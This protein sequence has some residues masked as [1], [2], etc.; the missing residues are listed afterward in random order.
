M[1]LTL[2]EAQTLRAAYLA[3][4]TA[5]ASGQSYTIGSRS[6]TRANLAEVKK[7]FAEYDA[8]VDDLTN[9]TTGGGV[10][11]FRVIPRDL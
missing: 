8:L 3:A 11:A 1:A 4:L 7:A 6:L 5:I 10:R 9:G 2:A